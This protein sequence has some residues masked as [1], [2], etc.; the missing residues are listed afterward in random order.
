LEAQLNISIISR[1]RIVRRSISIPVYE[2][3]IDAPKHEVVGMLLML[4]A[5]TIPFLML[6]NFI[7]PGF[8]PAFIGFILALAGGLTFLI[9]DIY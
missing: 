8:V 4:G 1:R 6:L 7:E 5:L 2:L 3:G 9:D